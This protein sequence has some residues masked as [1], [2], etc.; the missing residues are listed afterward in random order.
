MEE[1]LNNGHIVSLDL[2]FQQMPVFEKL[3]ADCQGDLPLFFKK[4]NHLKLHEP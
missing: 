4:A 1:D 2:Y 3:L